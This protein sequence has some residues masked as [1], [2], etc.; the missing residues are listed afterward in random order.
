MAFRDPIP[1]VYFPPKDNSI[2]NIIILLLI[3]FVIVIA[4]VLYVSLRRL[5]VKQCKLDIDCSSSKG[6]CDRT[7]GLCVECL[8][9]SDCSSGLFCSTAH[10]CV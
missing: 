8:Q 3:V 5:L 4:I 2:V 9:T 7:T 6:K 1:T 10:T